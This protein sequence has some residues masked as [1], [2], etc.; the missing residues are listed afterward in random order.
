MYNTQLNSILTITLFLL[1]QTRVDAVPQQNFLTTPSGLLIPQTRL[2]AHFPKDTDGAQMAS[3]VH[4][5]T[6]DLRLLSATRQHDL[7]GMLG[8][9]EKL[10]NHPVFTYVNGRLRNTKSSGYIRRGHGY[11]LVT[12]DHANVVALE[13]PAK[14]IRPLDLLEYPNVFIDVGEHSD[15]VTF[16]PDAHVPAVLPDDPEEM[17]SDGKPAENETNVFSVSQ[18]EPSCRG[19]NAPPQYVELA[20]AVDSVMC[21]LHGNDPSKVK[22]AVAAMLSSADAVYAAKMCIRFKVVVYDIICDSRND[23]YATISISEPLPDIRTIWPTRPA[24]S[25]PRD[26]V[27][28]LTGTNFKGGVAGQAYIGVTCFESFS[29]LWMDNLYSLVFVHEM[30]HNLNAEHT[31]EGIMKPGIDLRVDNYFSDTSVNEIVAF[32]DAESSRSRCI[33]TGPSVASPP[34]STS[35]QTCDSALSKWESVACTDSLARWRTRVSVSTD[36]FTGKATVNLYLSQAFGYSVSATAPRGVTLTKD[37]ATKTLQATVRSMNVVS[38]FEKLTKRQ[39]SKSSTRTVRDGRT[40]TGAHY[41][42]DVSVPDGLASCCGTKMF[43]NILLKIRVYDGSGF[44]KTYSRL[45]RKAVALKCTTWTGCSG[46]FV[47]ASANRQ[48]AV[49]NSWSVTFSFVQLY[50]VC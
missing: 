40:L 1:L 9:A 2:A 44:D 29:F 28:F 19:A 13:I 20:V 33:E 48:C 4:E 23:P 3:R 42:G 36:G 22:T 43:V 41:P 38:S 37:G 27:L 18:I 34:P 50:R 49:C 35:A 26:A 16:G 47:A 8:A 14:V 46:G 25:V 39:V 31:T 45:A 15:L 7:N 24:A 12:D 17:L 21:A 10:S 11:S 30:G 32:V 5:L 6:D